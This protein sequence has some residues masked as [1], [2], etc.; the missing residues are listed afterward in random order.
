MIALQ[1]LGPERTG[2]LWFCILQSCF[3][4]SKP[5]R[6]GLKWFLMLEMCGHFWTL[7]GLW[8]VEFTIS[9]S[10]GMNRLSILQSD[11]Y[12]YETCNNKISLDCLLLL[13]GFE[14]YFWGRGSHTHTPYNMHH[15]IPCTM[16][17]LWV[18]L[19]NGFCVRKPNSSWE[20]FSSFS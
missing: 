8:R 12:C 20:R 7:W 4:V 17:P 10:W 19:K 14:S 16:F 1:S 2:F 5:C 15:E 18:R 11:I 3:L 9:L 6:F 13:N